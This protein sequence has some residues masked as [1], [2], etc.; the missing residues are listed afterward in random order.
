[1]AEPLRVMDSKRW[2]R[3]IAGIVLPAHKSASTQ[4]PLAPAPLPSELILPLEGG[5]SA[6]D[7]RPTV[8]TGQRVLRGQPL[9]QGGGPLSTWTHASTSG[10]V[11]SLERRP[12][13]HPRRRE[14]L[15][16]VL[17]VDGR[18]EW[19]PELERPDPTQWD[20]PEK[21][22]VAL[23]RAGL[24]G[25]GGAVFPTGVKLAATWR[26]RMRL[27]IVNG[28]ECE[29]YI[30]CDDLLMRTAP[31]DVLAGALALV[32]LTGAEH[33]VVVVEEDKQE[34]LGALQRT[35]PMLDTQQQLTIVS[36]PTRYPA[37]G[38]RQLVEALT[39]HEVPS[40]AKPT[41]IGYLCQNVGTAAALFQYLASGR[42]VTSRVTTVTGGA[43]AMPRNL[44]VRLGTR[45]ADLVAACGG[46]TGPVGRLI[47]GGS[48]MGVALQSDQVAVG[49]A[50]N[51]IIAASD[52][53][54]RRS[55]EE[56]PCIRCGNCVE[57][58]PA[59]LEPLEL[60]FAA[61][62]NDFDALEE[63]GLF[64]CIEC[65][66]CDVVCPSH[67]QLTDRFR[68][69]KRNLV[70]AL[71]HDTRVRWLDARE[72]LRRERVKR[73]ER[74]HGG[75]AGAGAG[76]GDGGG[77]PRGRLEAVADVVA[78]ASRA[79]AATMSPGETNA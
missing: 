33:G 39:G 66:C 56:L 52:E 24:A 9:V 50:T 71:D 11:R 59:Y 21:L 23:S 19:W 18:D 64:D 58:C 55:F 1:M 42:P 43:I 69:G 51:C 13:A 10:V 68:A 26:G 48:M 49:R 32:E 4:L 75:G 17:E 22:G 31:R 72:Q 57:V 67:I 16:A 7:L 77:R 47:M 40:L 27:V 30:S 6:R 44:E 63:R 38:E 29:P 61:Q 37:G 78:R 79:P 62:R 73:W 15:C 60:F 20:T 25:L 65:G 46:Y 34:A 3:G 2:G 35:L 53:E 76:D 41:D 8:E 28:V 14:A 70:Q 74:E 45:I 54:V 36:V 12:V 5:L